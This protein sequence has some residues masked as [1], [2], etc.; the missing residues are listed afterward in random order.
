MKSQLLTFNEAMEFLKISKGTL[1]KLIHKED[2][3]A[4]RVGNLWRIDKEELISWTKK[5]QT[6][7]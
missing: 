6:K 7:N 5:Q 2:I 1:N 3:P 4:Y